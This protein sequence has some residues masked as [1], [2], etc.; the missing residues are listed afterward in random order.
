MET[1]DLVVIGA[2]PAGENVAGRATAAGLTACIVESELVGGECSYWACMPSKVMLRA[3]AALRSAQRV[4][5][6]EAAAEL[7]IDP[8]A[9]LERRRAI[10]SDWDDKYQVQWLDD[11][12]I[13]L[14]RGS[15]RLTKTPK[16]VEVVGKEG[17]ITTLEARRAVVVATGTAA[18]S[19]PIRGLA[20][21]QPWTNREIT[22]IKNI[23]ERLIILGGGV[24]G[25]EMAQALRDL[26]AKE[27]TV[28]ER[29]PRLISREEP[30]ASEILTRTFTE[31]Y[32]IAVMT[33]VNVVSVERNVSGVTVLN[34]DDATKVVGDKLLSATGRRPLTEGI[35]LEHVG[36]KSGDYIKV[37]DKL[38]AEG[39]AGDW[40]YAVGDA[41]GRSLLTHTGKYQARIAADVILG[42]DAASWGDIKAVPRIIF[43]DP[44]VAASGMTAAD[45]EAAGIPT[46]VVDYKFEHT[47]AAAAHGKGVTGQARMVVN[48]DTETIIGMTFVAAGAGEM[49]HAATI[50]I[51]GQV[52]LRDLWH[53]IPPFP[54]LS[55]VWLRLLEEY[56]L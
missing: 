21:Y 51:A 45:A 17:Q 37:N 27:V 6:L 47:A 55:E 19:P 25:V 22:E 35:G 2:G 7:G 48:T 32:G 41:N 42:K 54:S 40:L 29:G 23:P 1:Y 4:P 49:I 28:I 26:G 24:V 14:F 33:G 46:R 3:G 39:V 53:A 20:E 11:N 16:V 18:S 56:G 9:V 38:Q 15:G 8:E 31:Q 50:A 30:F 5:G 43:T 52:K 34:L 12:N 36:L 10:V 44:E 13:V